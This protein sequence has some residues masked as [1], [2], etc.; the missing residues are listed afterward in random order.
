VNP[1]CLII[2]NSVYR[3]ST[4]QAKE[5]EINTNGYIE[6]ND[7]VTWKATHYFGIPQKSTVNITQFE[8]PDY[9]VDAMASGAFKQFRHF[10]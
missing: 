3:W 7:T 6:L 5:R 9:F 2:K 8:S 4:S 1:T 10:P